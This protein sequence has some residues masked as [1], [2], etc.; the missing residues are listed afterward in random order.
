MDIVANR[1]NQLPIAAGRLISRISPDG[2]TVFTRQNVSVSALA[3][4]DSQTE[5]FSLEIAEQLFLSQTGL[6]GT[7]LSDPE[8]FETTV[9]TF[10]RDG[11]PS[12]SVG[13]VPGFDRTG[14]FSGDE[15]RIILLETFDTRSFVIIDTP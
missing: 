3:T 9:S 1:R 8:F 7:T 14:F 5:F 4:D 15:A 11:T 10:D 6:I 12:G 13:G 2:S